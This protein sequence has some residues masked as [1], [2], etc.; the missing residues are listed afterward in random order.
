MPRRLV[1][2]AALA[3]AVALSAG[4]ADDVAPAATVGDST[5]ISTDDL[6]AEV[7]AW[8]GSPGMLAALQVSEPAGASEGS[9]STAFVG[10]VLTFRLTFALHNAE[11]DELGLELSEQQLSEVRSALFGD[12]ATSAEV[13]EELGP[14][15]GDQ[16]V[17]DAA[18]RFAVTEALGEEGYQAWLAEAYTS[19]E[20]EVNP[21]YGSWDRVSGSVVPP[22]GPRS[23]PSANPFA[24][25]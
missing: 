18:R 21:R 11:F 7:A 12:A 13:L 22:E 6:M 23:A 5:E 4:C 25:L 14:R 2:L 8:A 19:T 16:L 3:L 24:E 9:Y 17:E 20:I 15:V 10:N 1:S